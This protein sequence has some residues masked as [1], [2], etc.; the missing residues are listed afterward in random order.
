M[1]GGV[2]EAAEAGIMVTV[3]IRMTTEALIVGGIM[4]TGIV[5]KLIEVRPAIKVTRNRSNVVVATA[6]MTKEKRVLNGKEK[7]TSFGCQF[8]GPK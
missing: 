7:E 6:N 5:I 3:V 4:E 1:I 8:S 2:V